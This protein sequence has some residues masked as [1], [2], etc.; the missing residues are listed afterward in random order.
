MSN[1]REIP[2]I[3]YNRKWFN[4]LFFIVEDIVNNLPK[5]KRVFIYGGKSSSKTVSV[6]Q[7]LAKR[8]LERRENSI[9]FRKES[10][11][12]KTTIKKSFELGIK[13]TRL[14]EGWTKYDRRF[15]SI[16]GG[17]V[18]LTGLDSEDKAKGVEGFNF[19]L[20]DEL[21]QFAHNEFT[22]ANLS[23][24]GEGRKVFF[25]TWNPVSKRSWV[26]TK[27]VDSYN[28]TSTAYELPDQNS[29]VKI[30]SCGTT[31]LIKTS[32]KD[33]YWTVGS[34][35]KTYGFVDQNLIDDYESLK[36]RD[37]NAYNVNVLGKWGNVNRG[38]EAYKEFK[39]DLHVKRH[40]YNPDLPLHLSF[41]EN[42]NPYLTLSIYQAQSKKAYKID[43]I[44]LEHPK[45]TLAYTI[46]E[47]KRRYPKNGN[48]VFIYGDRTSLKADTKLEKG[49]NFFSIIQ[50]NLK[51]DSYKT[52]LKLPSKNPPV[53][54]RINFINEIF[55]S[56][57]YDI[58]YSVDENCLNT[59]DDYENVKEDSNGGK[60][61]KRV[62]N[63]VT[64][65][66]YEEYGHLTDT[67][68]Y[69]LCEYFKKEFKK[70][71]GTRSRRRISAS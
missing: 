67:D 32:Y 9:M 61:K 39:N 6:C 18:V 63:P 45:N 24:R 2:V 21:D 37:R 22:Q 34:P 46:T 8:G 19:V 59:I 66:S 69:F 28:W 64:K 53:S 71:S 70:Y 29:F 54:L 7:L 43:E 65:V 25:G 10:A 47:F 52:S 15:E 58:E 5:V 14:T 56:N 51:R 30:S 27:L 42:V 31:I 3:E 48:T 13:T 35:C 44:C 57:I 41:D 26:K 11:R 50:S 20:Y 49:Q 55:S 60:L 16:T 36:T 4:P 68:D 38:G 17:E 12:V 1:Q 33:N 62:T 40:K 23:L